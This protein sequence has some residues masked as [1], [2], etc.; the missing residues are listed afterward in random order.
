M[1]GLFMVQD[2]VGEIFWPLSDAWLSGLSNAA[3]LA[4]ALQMSLVLV[5]G[6]ALATSPPVV[7]CLDWLAK[8]PRTGAGATLLVAAVACC[9]GVIHWGLGAVAGAVVARR[10]ASTSEERGLAIHYPLLGAAAYTGFAVWHGGLSGSAPLKIAQGA[11]DGSVVVPVQ[12]TLFSPLNLV[13]TGFLVLTIPL[14]CAWLVPRCPDARV[15]GPVARLAAD[16]A[17]QPTGNRWLG[18]AIGFFCLAITI[19][20]LVTGRFR[21]DINSVNALFLFLGIL[22]HGDLARYAATVRQGASA[23]GAI[24]VQFPLYFGILGLLRASGLVAWLSEQLVSLSN[25]TTLPVWTFLSAGLVNVFVPSGGGQWAV[26]SDILLRAA[27]DLE[28]SLG[29]SVMAFSYGDAWTNMLQPFWA[30]PVLGIMGLRARDI[31]GYT[32]AICLYI[33]LVVPLWLLIL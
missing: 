30:L 8:R 14:L 5:T 29:T 2:G 13:I 18:R 19:L 9:A 21:F 23:A 24:I 22:C 6:H 3:G 31:I 7:R 11:L 12:E 4:F 10:I 16:P 28:V 32:A 26:Q 20:S 15:S 25:A 17:D 27:T 1:A 33:G